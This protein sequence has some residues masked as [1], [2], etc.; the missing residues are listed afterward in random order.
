MLCFFIPPQKGGMSPSR[1]ERDFALGIFFSPK[2]KK[3][4]QLFINSVTYQEKIIPLIVGQRLLALLNG[5]FA[6]TGRVGEGL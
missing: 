1:E 5:R 4:L 3:I 6:G 2:V